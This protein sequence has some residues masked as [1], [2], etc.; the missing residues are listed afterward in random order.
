MSENQ[1]FTGRE[2]FLTKLPFLLEEE[3]VLVEAAYI[4]AKY[5]HRN[6]QR[7]GGERYFEH[8]R[9]VAN[10]I[11]DEL[12]INNDWQLIVTALLHDIREDSFLLNEWLTKKIFDRQVALWLKILTKESEFY[13][14]NLLKAKIWQV[15]LIKLCDR[16]HN[17][18]TL[19]YRPIAKQIEQI[20]ET[21]QFILPLADELFLCLPAEHKWWANYLWSEINAICCEYE[22]RLQINYS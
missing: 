4:L 8:P 21:R 19:H 10:I 16:L 7:E 15:W 6:Q 2:Q 20:V 13:F 12:G 22:A 3:L 11:I 1:T 17:L 9:A 14:I 18:R 5:G